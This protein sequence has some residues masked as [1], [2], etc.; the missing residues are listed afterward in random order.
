MKKIPL[1]SLLVAVLVVYAA[2]AAMAAKIEICHF[3]PG[4]PGNWHTITINDTALPAHQAHNDLVGSCLANCETICDDGNKCTVDVVPNNTQCQCQAQPHPAVDCSDGQ[5][6]TTDSCDPAQGCLYT[7][8][9]C[10]APDL[11][12]VS[13]CSEPGGSCENTPV[14][15]P[16]GEACNPSTGACELSMSI[17]TF[18]SLATPGTSYTFRSA[19][20]TEVGFTVSTSM[21]FCVIQSE[22][23]NLYMG[24]TGLANCNQ[25]GINTLTKVGGGTFTIV[26]IDLAPFGRFL[27]PGSPYGGGASVPFVGYKADGSTVSIT[28]TAPPDAAPFPAY[29]FQTY[30]FTGFDNLVSVSWTHVSPYHQ[31]DNIK[32]Q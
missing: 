12:T 17:M 6:C 27:D 4:N 24:S 18:E 15:C 25:N 14:V 22:N 29:A 13:L 1:L 2:M 9:V 8:V 31:F 3:P 5:T 20:Y 23:P 21:F 19:P 16:T 10:Q 32:L 7:A 30:S 26:S 28:F 11:C